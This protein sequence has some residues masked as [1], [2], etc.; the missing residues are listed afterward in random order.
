[1][2]SGKLGSVTRAASRSCDLVSVLALNICLRGLKTCNTIYLNM[3]E[4]GDVLTGSCRA[5]HR[6]NAEHSYHKCKACGKPNQWKLVLVL[7]WVDNLGSVIPERC[8]N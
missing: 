6:L 5:Y 3:I 4:S 1:V 8:G 7:C 2:S